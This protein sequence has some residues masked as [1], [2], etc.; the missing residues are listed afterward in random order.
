M[1]HDEVVA[2]VRYHEYDKKYPKIF[3]RNGFIGD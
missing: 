2:Y 3:D 1:P